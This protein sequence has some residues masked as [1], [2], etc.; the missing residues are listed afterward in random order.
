[1]DAIAT[2]EH[3]PYLNPIQVELRGSNTTHTHMCMYMYVQCI[4]KLNADPG[5]WG[6][7]LELIKPCLPTCKPHLSVGKINAVKGAN[8]S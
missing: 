3:Q 7:G 2:G 1:M 5:F 4:I 6:G 8:K